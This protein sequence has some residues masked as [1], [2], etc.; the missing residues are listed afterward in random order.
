MKVLVLGA[1]VIGVTTA[2]RLLQDGHEVTVAE[3]NPTAAEE[4][5]ANNA[6]LVAPGHADAW[7]SPRAPMILLR[8]LWRNDQAPAL[9]AA[10]GPAALALV[11]A[12]PAPMHR[13]SG[14][15][16]HPAQAP[17]L[18]LFPRPPCRR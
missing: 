8:S 18:R 7:S 4:T 12:V 11:L 17:A 3:R 9:Q 5:S 1:G 15:G 10:G 14:A 16:Q 13:R 6:G 2:Y